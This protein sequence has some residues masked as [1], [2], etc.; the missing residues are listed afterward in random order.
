M[1]CPIPGGFLVAIE[2]I[3]G[4]GKTTQVQMLAQLCA[5]NRLETVVSKEPTDSVFGSI[6]RLSARRGRLSLEEE[7]DLFMKD[8]REHV[9]DLINPALRADKIVILDRYYFSTA[10]YQG[11]RGADPKAIIQANDIFA[12]EPDLLVILDVPPS[13]GL[14]RVR[15]RGDDPN[16]FEIE[17]SLEK[18]RQIF[19]QIERQYL[20]RLDARTGPEIIHFHI[21]NAFQTLAANKIGK[22]DFSPSGVNRMLEL[23][24]EHPIPPQS[25]CSLI[26]KHA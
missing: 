13:L 3:D 7:L 25:D 15:E 20:L 5:D 10:A 18:A 11:A 2:G 12:P 17:V 24:S 22:H 8:R 9:D 19:N 16:L 23:F 1:R 26:W 6:L 21:A 14:N 4:A